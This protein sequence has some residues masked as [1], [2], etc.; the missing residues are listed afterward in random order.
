[1]CQDPREEYKFLRLILEEVKWEKF[2]GEKRRLSFCSVIKFRVVR[3]KYGKV[4]SMRFGLRVEKG[5]RRPKIYLRLWRAKDLKRFPTPSSCFPHRPRHPSPSLPSSGQPK[6]SFPFLNWMKIQLN[7]FP[8]LVG[9]F[10]E[11]PRPILIL[12]LR[13]LFLSLPA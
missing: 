9:I 11:K 8:L 12:L 5:E 1:M 7:F 13:R 4:S 3:K 6:K 10:R 2:S